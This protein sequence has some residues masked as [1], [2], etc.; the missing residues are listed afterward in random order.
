MMSSSWKRSGACGTDAAR[1]ADT[2]ILL[3]VHLRHHFLEPCCRLPAGSGPQQGAVTAQDCALARQQCRVLLDDRPRIK[4]GEPAARADPVGNR[5]QLAGGYDVG[6]GE[7]KLQHPP[8]R[9]DIIA[10]VT[11]GTTSFHVTH[12]QMP[13]V[14]PLDGSNALHYPP[15]K[16]LLRSQRGLVI[17][18]NA[19]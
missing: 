12:E 9:F 4:A 17:E 11:P 16:E 2:S 6:V 1:S 19:H 10:R 14:A 13:P 3:A 15:R 7:L 18:Q 5:V 8:H